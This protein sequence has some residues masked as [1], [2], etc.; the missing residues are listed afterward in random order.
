MTVAIAGICDLKKCNAGWS[1]P[2]LAGAGRFAREARQVIVSKCEGCA[3]ELDG[4]ALK[5]TCG[6]CVA[7]AFEG[8]QDVECTLLVCIDD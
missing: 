8:H 2:Y 6:N 5:L 1:E 3:I 4:S 7:L